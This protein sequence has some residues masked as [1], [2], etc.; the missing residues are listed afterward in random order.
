MTCMKNSTS[1]VIMKHLAVQ[2]DVH[3]VHRRW[4]IPIV[5]LVQTTSIDNHKLMDFGYA[6]T[7]V[8]QVSHHRS[9]MALLT[10]AMVLLGL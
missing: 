4:T 3:L 9:I 10:H 6:L 7:T 8:Q 2:M 5:H 1:E